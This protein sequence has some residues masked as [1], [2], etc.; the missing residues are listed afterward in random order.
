MSFCFALGI[1]FTCVYAALFLSVPK[2]LTQK[3]KNGWQLVTKGIVCWGLC[4][5]YILDRMHCVGMQL[6]QAFFKNRY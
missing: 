5:S 6:K 3:P 4:K 1:I 2:S